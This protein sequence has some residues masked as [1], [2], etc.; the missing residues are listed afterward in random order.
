M[1][2]F[3]NRVV[4]ITGAASGIG[5]AAAEAFARE[6]ARLALAD[7]D[8]PRLRETVQSASLASA[9][10]LELAGDA[11]AEPAVK[12]M[13][14]K[15]A[16]R[17]GRLDVLLNSAGI[18]LRAA[19]TETRLEDWDRIMAVNVRAMF[20]MCKHAIPLLLASGG[21]AIVNISSASGL[22]P[23]AG[24]PAYNASKGAVIALTKS[25]AVDCAPAIRANCVC[26]GAV[27]TPLLLESIPEA[28]GREA[29]LA[30]VAQRYPLGRLAEPEEI[31]RAALFLASSEASYI[32]GAAFPVD[33]GR[34]LH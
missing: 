2:R 12:Q 10:A 18:D 26:P 15:T 14:E 16:S 3:E 5:R 6:G 23:M 30:E 7:V 22:A 31:A 24:R 11:S 34:T 27:R 9:G 17:F 1:R 8:E 32:T 20:L 29:K 33:G 13:L 28:A 4:L 19:I 21:G 25:L